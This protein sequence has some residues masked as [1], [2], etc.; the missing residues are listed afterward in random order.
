MTV[1]AKPVSDRLPSSAVRVQQSLQSMGLSASVVEL[2]S[3][4]RTAQDAATAI[5]C[6]VRQIAKSIVFRRGDNNLP[7]LVIASGIN[8]VDERRVSSLLRT[9]VQRADADYVRSQTGF[10]I[11]GVPP[12]G[13]SSPIQVLIDQ[14]LLQLEIIWAAGG[15]PRTVFSLNPTDLVTATKGLVANIAYQSAVRP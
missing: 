8:R 5:G 3:S 6:S 14:D 15:T 2:P 7:I 9:L 13:H 11:G 10:A 1:K 12:V 4:T